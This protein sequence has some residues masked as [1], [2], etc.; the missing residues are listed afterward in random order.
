[1]DDVSAASKPRLSEGR[2][3]ITNA[4]YRYM[5]RKR[6]AEE[7]GDRFGRLLLLGTVLATMA[8]ERWKERPN[9]GL[10]AYRSSLFVNPIKKLAQQQL[11]KERPYRINSHLL[12]QIIDKKLFELIVDIFATF[13]G[14]ALKLSARR[15]VS[16]IQFRPINPPDRSGYRR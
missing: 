7:A 11:S 8:V 15:H 16:P 9:R 2:S 10:T 6:D 4:L 3:A 1:A 13:A 14:D 12:R 5:L